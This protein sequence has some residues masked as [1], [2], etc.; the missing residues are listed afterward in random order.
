MKN[1]YALIMAPAVLSVL[2]AEAAPV[3]EAA[4]EAQAEANAYKGAVVNCDMGW[5]VDSMYPPLKWTLADRLASRDP[6]TERENAH[7]IMGTGNKRE[8]EEVARRR[9][10]RSIRALKDEYVRMG[11]QMK[12]AGFKVERYVVGTPMAE[13]VLPHSST[14]T[15]AIRQDSL[16]QRGRRLTS[17]ENI[18][19]EG[20]YSRLV[21]LPTTLWY[22]IPTESGSRLRIERK[23]F[24]YA[25][26]DEKIQASNNRN[27]RGTIINKWYF[28]D[29]NT[30]VNTLRSY[31]PT[32][33]LNIA[34]PDTG[35]R[36]LQ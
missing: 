25:V 9:M 26:R 12:K 4:R 15:H 36:P 35:E 13:Y 6:R 5:A 16:Q 28:I 24:I 2:T 33:P 22:S 18:K 21:V 1:L 32:L 11:E 10:E 31:F 3:S 23:D 7:R 34:R 19:W 20:G 14:A 29:G 17:A 8:S 27:F 30:D